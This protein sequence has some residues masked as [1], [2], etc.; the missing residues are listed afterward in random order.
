MYIAELKGKL[1][2]NI[3][4]SE[5]ILTSNVFSFF[6]Y[7][8][9]TIFLKELLFK[10]GFN[11]SDDDL[12]SAQFLF[13]PRYDDNTEPDLVIIV[14]YYYIL[15]EAKYFSGFGQETDN[16]KSQLLREVEGGILEAKVLKKQFVLVAITADYSYKSNK[17]IE[18]KTFP[19]IQFKWVNW[20]L[21]S[22][23]LANYLS[24]HDEQ[25]S[26]YLI[27]RDLYDLL[28]KKNLRTF[29]SFNNLKYNPM[30][31]ISDKVFFKAETTKYRGAF[32]GFNKALQNQKIVAHSKNNVF[33]SKTY[34]NGLTKK[35]LYKADRIFFEGARKNG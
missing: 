34:F 5:D 18:V 16:K 22:N 6:K 10:I 28:E 27:S 4:R 9:R 21:V 26:D 2:S 8:S 13:W 33:F 25:Y 32:I 19:N 35:N 24:E 23:I 20:Q 17:F 7:S 1:S 12:I 3:E 30:S 11:L 15:I 14:G 31:T 29:I